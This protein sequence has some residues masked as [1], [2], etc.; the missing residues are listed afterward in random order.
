LSPSLRA[1]VILPVLLLPTPCA[2]IPRF[3]AHLEGGFGSMD[4]R[5]LPS[6]T[7][8]GVMFW[9]GFGVPVR[10]G[11]ITLD[12][13][14]SAG[15]EIGLQV[16]EGTHSGDRSLSTLLLGIE[17]IN[18]ETGR[19]FFASTGLGIG[20]ARLSGA[21]GEFSNP[22]WAIPYRDLVGLAFGLGLGAR[23]Y[24]GPGPLGLQ[25]ALRFHGL[26]RERHVAASGTMLT[27]GLGY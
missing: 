9:T 2:A 17:A 20:R 1:L 18:H 14:M 8:F 24:N 15:Q 27:L 11:R 25:L 5:P 13:G 22:A 4:A 10:P 23:S 6:P 12:Y 19:G 3:S 21:S 7:T 16:P 26:V